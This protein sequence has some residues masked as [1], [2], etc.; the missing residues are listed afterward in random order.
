[1]PK[2]L[3]HT[4]SSSL[5]PSILVLMLVTIR[6]EVVGERRESIECECEREIKETVSLHWNGK[7]IIAWEMKLE[8]CR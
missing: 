1:M 7:D 4:I 8:L 2:A 3:L 5:L 6:H